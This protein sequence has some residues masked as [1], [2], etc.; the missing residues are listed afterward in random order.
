MKQSSANRY[1]YRITG[2]DRKNCAGTQS[3]E[4]ITASRP[5]KPGE[6]RLAFESAAGLRLILPAE[7]PGVLSLGSGCQR[8]GIGPLIR[9]HTQL[10]VNKGHRW[11]TCTDAPRARH[12]AAPGRGVIVCA[13][14]DW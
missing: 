12:S 8:F 1:V 9:S 13:S 2:R 11:V 7:M 5:L 3:D 4:L 6:L 14:R 10:P